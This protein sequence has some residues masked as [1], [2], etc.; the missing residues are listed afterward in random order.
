[1]VNSCEVSIDEILVSFFISVRTLF[2]LEAL[3][4]F[5]LARNQWKFLNV[6]APLVR[7]RAVRRLRLNLKM[8]MVVFISFLHA[9]YK[10]VVNITQ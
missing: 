7:K 9:A 4:Y 6:S 10:V 3:F 5:N 1:M 8:Y 2:S